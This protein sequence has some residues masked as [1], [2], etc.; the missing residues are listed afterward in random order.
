MDVEHG[1]AIPGFEQPERFANLVSARDSLVRWLPTGLVLFV[2][3]WVLS[4]IVVGI[5]FSVP[6]DVLWGAV[7]AIVST[8]VWLLLVRTD[9]RRNLARRALVVSPDGITFEERVTIT[10]IPWSGVTAVTRAGATGTAGRGDDGV[11]GVGAVTVRPEASPFAQELAR[12]AERRRP[13]RPGT[14]EP[15]REVPFTPFEADWESG[16]LGAWLHAYRPDLTPDRRSS[17]APV[18]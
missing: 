11:V 5:L 6:H 16:R 1:R 14:D 9:H 8:G 3:I 18:D 17:D 15:L 7:V 4:L 12:A 2:A 10:E 13:R